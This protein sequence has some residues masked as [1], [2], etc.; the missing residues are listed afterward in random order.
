M[1]WTELPQHNDHY[2]I[3]S[4]LPFSPTLLDIRDKTLQE[5]LKWTGVSSSSELNSYQI[6]SIMFNSPYNCSISSLYCREFH[7][8]SGRNS[9]A[10]KKIEAKNTVYIWHLLT[11]FLLGGNN[12][13]YNS[14]YISFTVTQ[15]ISKAYI[16]NLLH[17]LNLFSIY[18]LLINS[19][20]FLATAII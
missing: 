11:A 14:E 3:R 20:Q 16:Q 17:E 5:P 7:F 19:L 15:T 2:G 9:T 1:C 8:W 4:S 13:E 6:C 12:K 10:E 18:K